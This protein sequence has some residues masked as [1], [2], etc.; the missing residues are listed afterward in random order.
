MSWGFKSW[1]L[2][3][4]FVKV[5]LCRA[6]LHKSYNSERDGMISYVT[7]HNKHT[8]VMFLTTHSYFLEPVYI[9]KCQLVNAKK[10]C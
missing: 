10:R 4:T 5:N 8:N 3:L 7:Q 1:L 9:N 6:L 2:E